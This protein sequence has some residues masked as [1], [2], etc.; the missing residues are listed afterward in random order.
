MKLDPKN[1][2]KNHKEYQKLLKKYQ[3]KS[4]EEIPHEDLEKMLEL[5][6]SIYIG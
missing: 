2:I 5:Q 4:I 6:H 1:I 3:D